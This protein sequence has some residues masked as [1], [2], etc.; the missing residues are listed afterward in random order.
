MKSKEGQKYATENMI[1]D[2]KAIKDLEYVAEV[3]IYPTVYDNGIKLTVDI[4]EKKI[5]KLY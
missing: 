3:S 1:V 5:Q 4:T 2:Y